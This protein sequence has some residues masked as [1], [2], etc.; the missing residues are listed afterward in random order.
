MTA[1]TLARLL[2]RALTRSGQPDRG[3]ARLRRWRSCSP[4]GAHSTSGMGRPLYERNADV[5]RAPRRVRPA[6]RRLIWGGR[7]G[8]LVLGYADDAELIHQTRYTQPALFVL[9]YAVAK[10]WL[11]WGVRPS[12]L[13][14]H[15][16]GEIVAA[17]VAGLFTLTTPSP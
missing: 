17:T 3:P 1:M 10:L 13:V 16:I 12:V 4:A 2:D 7:S 15:S 6:V 9:E 5:P 8:D 14:G 11:S